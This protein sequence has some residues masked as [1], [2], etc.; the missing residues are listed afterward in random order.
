MHFLQSVL[1]INNCESFAC[2]LV[3]SAPH[4]SQITISYGSEASD[5][6]GAAGGLIHVLT[7]A[8]ACSAGVGAGIRSGSGE[9][10]SRVTDGEVFAG[11]TGD[12]IEVGVPTSGI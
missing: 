8:A 1:L 7:A 11:S 5:L 12:G 3:V 4:R 2:A 10:R 6:G 9:T